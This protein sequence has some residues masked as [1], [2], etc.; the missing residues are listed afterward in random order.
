MD[1]ALASDNNYVQHMAVVIESVIQNNVNENINFHIMNNGITGDNLIKIRHQIESRGKKV[2][3]YDFSGLED[4]VGFHS[5]SSVLPISAYSRIFL[6][7][8]LQVNVDRLIYMDVD[9]VCCG[10][11]ADTYSINMGKN[12][13]AAVQDFANIKARISNGLDIEDRYIN[14]GFMII[15]VNKWLEQGITNKLH[16]YILERDGKVVQE[17]QGAINS[18]LRNQIK[19]I[20]PKYNAMTPF[21]FVTSKEI[22]ERYNIPIY[23]SDKELKEAKS[24]PVIIHYLKY[25]GFV[26]RPWEKNCVHPMKNKYQQYLAQTEWAGVKLLPDKRTF[27][28]RIKDNYQLLC[29]WRIKK[30]IMKLKMNIKVW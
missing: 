20:H 26:N 17:D 22:K 30:Y 3:F 29:P 28:K 27:G 2:F 23:Y 5:H 21:Y 24:N 6:P 13:I 14:S 8:K 1:I 19:I 15:D 11:L 16:N 25:N 18:V 12:I 9:M 7:P 10:S 4:E